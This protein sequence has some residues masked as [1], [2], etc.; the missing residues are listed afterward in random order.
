VREVGDKEITSFLPKKIVKLLIDILFGGANIL[1]VCNG[2]TIWPGIQMDIHYLSI[3]LL[4][5]VIQAQI[6]TNT[7][8]YAYVALCNDNA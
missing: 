4:L 3:F 5:E 1:Q 6:E 7:H 2:I 8:T